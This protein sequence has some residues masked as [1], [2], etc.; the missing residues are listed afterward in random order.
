MRRTRILTALIDAIAIEDGQIEP[1][2]VGE[3]TTFP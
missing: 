2:T 3:V 1:P